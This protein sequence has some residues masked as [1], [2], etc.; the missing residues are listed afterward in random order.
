MIDLALWR[1]DATHCSNSDLLCVMSPVVAGFLERQ[2]ERSTE[3]PRR[4]SAP[5][6][7]KAELPNGAGARVA[8]NPAEHDGYRCLCG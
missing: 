3:R 5:A 2:P 1:R 7:A 8:I 6:G 4:A